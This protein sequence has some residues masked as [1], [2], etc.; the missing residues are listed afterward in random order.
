MPTM[1]WNRTATSQTWLFTPAIQYLRSCVTLWRHRQR[2]RLAGHHQTRAKTTIH[3]VLQEWYSVSRVFNLLFLL[4]LPNSTLAN[5]PSCNGDVYGSC[6]GSNSP[7]RCI[8]FTG[9]TA[10]QILSKLSLSLVRNIPTDATS[11]HTDWP[12]PLRC[13]FSIFQSN[14]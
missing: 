13:F 14:P 1:A 4:I 3:Q 10:V 5:I 6:S 8:S 9:K 12:G 11:T 2:W 7:H